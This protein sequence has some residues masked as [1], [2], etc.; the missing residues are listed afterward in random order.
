MEE[1]PDRESTMQV[2]MTPLKMASL[3]LELETINSC[4]TKLCPDTVVQDFTVFT[5][6]PI[7]DSIMRDIVDMEKKKKK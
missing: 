1:N 2:W 5:R 7:E 3:L 4:W 6:E